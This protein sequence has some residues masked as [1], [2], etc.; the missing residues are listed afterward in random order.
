MIGRRI[1]RNFKAVDLAKS[2]LLVLLI[3]WVPPMFRS[4]WVDELG[5]FWAIN[6]SLAEAV[7]R[8]PQANQSPFTFVLMW[9]WNRA[10]SPSDFGLRVL[11]V[12]FGLGALAVLY[13]TGKRLG[14]GAMGWYTVAAGAAMYEMRALVVNFRPYAFALFFFALSTRLLIAWDDKPSKGNAI[15]YMLATAATVW[16]V[17]YFGLAFAGHVLFVL[18]RRKEGGRSSLAGFFTMVSGAVV[19]CLPLIP[20]VVSLAARADTLQFSGIPS[21]RLVV[22]GLIPI[23]M[24][25]SW[26]LII[27]V[28]GLPSAWVVRRSDRVLIGWLAVAPTVVLYVLTVLT[29]FGLWT[30]RYRSVLLLG[31]A[32]AAAV[33]IAGYT[34]DR[35]RVRAI[36]ALLLVGVLV[37]PPN[38]FTSRQDWR[39]ALAMADSTIS[40]D[41]LLILGSGL[42]EASSLA[43]LDDEALSQFIAS[44]LSRYPVRQDVLLSP[45]LPGE[46]AFPYLIGRLKGS[47][48]DEIAVASLV[49]NPPSFDN[50]HLDLAPLGFSQVRVEIFG[51]VQV[52][53]YRRD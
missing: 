26:L 11:P 19:L 47:T 24:A 44:P 52:F 21:I 4:L 31:F 43:A 50:F 33:W 32:L 3:T 42:I 1:Y 2:S 14:G 40:G 9:A 35:A 8:A 5:T 13:S 28:S 51:T 41:G 46:T 37:S 30:V 20:Q 53:V 17:L 39:G 25:G 12:L 16:S 27:L 6:G 10:L 34:D 45:L 48:Y 7:S 49:G 36:I 18:W 29:D 15:G 38:D 23:G 22:D